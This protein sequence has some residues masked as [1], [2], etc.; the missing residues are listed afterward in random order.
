MQ[1][2]VVSPSIGGA[3]LTWGAV[4]FLSRLTNSEDVPYD[5][6]YELKDSELSESNGEVGCPETSTYSPLLSMWWSYYHD[7]HKDDSFCG[8]QGDDSVYLGCS[9]AK[10]LR[11]MLAPFLEEL[12]GDYS[13]LDSLNDGCELR[14]VEA[15]DGYHC[16][17][18]EDPE[19]GCEVVEEYPRIWVAM[20]DDEYRFIRIVREVCREASEKRKW[21][22]NA[23][24]LVY[25][26]TTGDGYSVKIATHKEY[27]VAKCT[28]DGEVSY[29]FL[30]KNTYYKKTDDH[31]QE[32]YEI[33]GDKENKFRLP[34]LFHPGNEVKAYCEL[35]A[36]IETG[37]KPADE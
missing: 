3:S 24:C 32:C 30:K 16:G 11:D 20:K 13:K 18:V 8:L 31:G 27:A 9:Y 22:C 23:T 34:V 29:L 4:K 35:I 21:N 5:A 14:I 15:P 33:V 25:D 2:F 6:A 26:W 17:V 37:V 28:K 1:K 19:T 7:R 36:F 10:P 12:G